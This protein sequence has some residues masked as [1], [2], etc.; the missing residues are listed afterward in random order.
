VKFDTLIALVEHF[1]AAV[2]LLIFTYGFRAGVLYVY[3]KDELTRQ[4]LLFVDDVMIVGVVI[5]LVWQLAVT[6]WN[7]RERIDFRVFVA[8]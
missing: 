3:P 1:M 4:I 6:L 8:A 5:F 7:R 2:P